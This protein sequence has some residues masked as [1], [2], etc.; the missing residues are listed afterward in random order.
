MRRLRWSLATLAFLVVAGVTF[1]SCLSHTL[2]QGTTG[3]E[4]DA[5][6]HRLEKG[7]AIDDWARTG[8]VRFTFRNDTHHLWD[9][10]RNL[11]RVRWGDD[12]VLLDVAKQ[13]GRATHKGRVLRGEEADEL[14]KKAYARFCNDTFWL[15]PLA[16][17]FDDGVTRSR[18]VDKDG[19]SLLVHYASGGTTP[20]DTYQWLIGEGDVPRAWRMFVHVIKIKGLEM[21]WQ[22]WQTLSTGA[23]VATRHRALG[24]D[25][26]KLTDIVGGATLADVEPGPDPFAAILQ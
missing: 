20:G 8:A 9:R 16:K 21:T 4:A 13:T 1:V 2:P 18:A 12:E 22:D 26:L 10:T 11:D 14:V 15:N 6:A 25:A 24:L 3:P 7:A 17:L 5:L 19:E 23:R